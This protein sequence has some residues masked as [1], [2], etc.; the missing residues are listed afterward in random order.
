M[1]RLTVEMLDRMQPVGNPE[2]VDISGADYTFTNAGTVKA[3]SSS[4]TVSGAVI[5][6]DILRDD[7]TTQTNVGLPGPGLFRVEKVTKIRQSGTT[8]TNIVGWHL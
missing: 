2:K 8:G 4:G 3:I 5:F 1:Q 7:G 6:A